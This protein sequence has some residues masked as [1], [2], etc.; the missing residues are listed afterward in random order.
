MMI[1]HNWYSGTFHT[2]THS[3][4]ATDTPTQGCVKPGMQARFLH[5]LM[6]RSQPLQ[7]NQ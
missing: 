2:L 6:C 1:T 7:N 5:L 3:Y 4:L